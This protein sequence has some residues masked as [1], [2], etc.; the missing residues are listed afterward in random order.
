MKF[1]QTLNMETIYIKAFTIW[2]MDNYVR[3]CFLGFL[4]FWGGWD[5]T[6]WMNCVFKLDCLF[7]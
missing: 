4:G 6:V 5:G 2:S 7:D 3:V 1:M